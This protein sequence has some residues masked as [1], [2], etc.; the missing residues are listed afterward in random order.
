MVTHTCSTSTSTSTWLH[1]KFFPHTPSH[2]HCKR[3]A[4]ALVPLTIQKQVLMLMEVK[5]WMNVLANTIRFVH[6]MSNSGLSYPYTAGKYI[7]RGRNFSQG[8]GFCTLRPKRLYFSMHPDSRYFVVFSFER[9]Q[10]ALP[11]VS[12]SSNISWLWL[13]AV[14]YHIKEVFSFLPS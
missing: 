7:P 12:V 2:C 1:N 8:R 14:Q 10:T 9:Q 4:T 3:M 11:S 13:Q 6:I 5:V